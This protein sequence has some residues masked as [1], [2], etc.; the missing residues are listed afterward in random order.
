M[1][2]I[3]KS[4]TFNSG[5]GQP[6]GA[7]GLD[8]LMKALGDLFGKL[9]QQGQQSGSGQQPPSS[10]PP[11]SGSF[12][13]QG[14]TQY[15]QTS[16]VSQLS[17]P[18][19]Q[20]VPTNSTTSID[21]SGLTGTS[22]GGIDMS[23]LLGGGSSNTSP[24]TNTGNTSTSSGTQTLISTI[25]NPPSGNSGVSSGI[26]RIVFLGTSTNLGG[27]TA[28][29]SLS[30]D[31]MTLGGGIT[32]FGN[33][34]DQ[35]SNTEVAGFYGGDSFGGQPQGLVAQWC[36]SRP[37]ASNFLSS[38]IPPSFF[39][40]LC[41]SRGYQVGTPPPPSQP[42]I[43]HVNTPPPPPP[44][45]TTPSAQSTAQIWAVPAS[46]PLGARTEIFW[47]TQGVTNC[48]ET[49]PDGSFNQTSLS[50]GAATVPLT[51]ATTFT[52]SC[53]APDGSHVTNYVTVNLSI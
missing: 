22:T 38:I 8:Q 12:G 25:I 52:I 1:G 4:T 27:L 40:G 23:T 5:A 42:V 6:G 13:S 36:I 35:Q 50:G 43:Q 49:S 21:L 34:F 28:S 29:S 7:A 2:S 14:C 19:A 33:R 10:Q 20:Y 48:T 53:L 24:N 16:D 46:V 11:S 47:N 3:C 51:G 32:A 41:S 18:C 17:N 30:G 37:W 39:D 26:P 9:M 45:T 15:F 44:A 31:I